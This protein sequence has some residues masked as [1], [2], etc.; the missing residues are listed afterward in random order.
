MPSK[1]QSYQR[2]ADYFFGK[3]MSQDGPVN[4][5]DEDWANYQIALLR[6][7]ANQVTSSYSIDE[8]KAQLGQSNL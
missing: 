4:S 8:I 6:L 3:L 1:D 2:H 7:I 5:L